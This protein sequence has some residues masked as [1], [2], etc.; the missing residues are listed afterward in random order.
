MTVFGALGGFLLY[1]VWPFL[2]APGRINDYVKSIGL[3]AGTWP[4]FIL[5]FA[6]MNAFLEEYYWRGLL[7][8]GSK[9]ISLNDLSFSGYHVVV[10]LGGI[11]VTWLAAVFLILLLAAWTWRQVNRLNAGL[12]SSLACHIAADISVILVAYLMTR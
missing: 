10:L 9:I 11:S 1:Y 7:D 6:V 3:T 5:Y 4:L 12:L 8:N 2:A